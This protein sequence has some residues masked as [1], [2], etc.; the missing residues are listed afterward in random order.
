VLRSIAAPSVIV[1]RLAFGSTSAVTR[2]AFAAGT[3]ADPKIPA[4]K[5]AVATAVANFFLMI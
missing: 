4:S 5:L 1:V 3:N 2:A